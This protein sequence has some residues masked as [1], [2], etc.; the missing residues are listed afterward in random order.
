MPKKSK[1]V[2]YIEKCKKDKYLRQYCS[3]KC[4]TP[5]FPGEENIY[6]LKL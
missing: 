3:Y 5:D 4:L 1:I 6:Q 2:N